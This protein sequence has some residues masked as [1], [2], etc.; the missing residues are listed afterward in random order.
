MDVNTLKL[1]MSDAAWAEKLARELVEQPFQYGFEKYEHGNEIGHG[2]LMAVAFCDP[3]THV[4]KLQG[5]KSAEDFMLGRSMRKT[6]SKDALQARRQAKAD[7][8]K[9][10]QRPKTSHAK[11]STKK[12]S[13]NSPNNRSRQSRVEI[14]NS[15]SPSKRRLLSPPRSNLLNR[16]KKR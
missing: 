7:A 5:S 1:M 11:T 10:A 8:L 12:Q 2:S 16:F 14:L 3:R 9:K 4:T 6:V 15:Y 13:S